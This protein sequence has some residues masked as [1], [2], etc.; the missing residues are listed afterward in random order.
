MGSSLTAV[1]RPPLTRERVPERVRRRPQLRR[2]MREEARAA[3]ARGTVLA[4][5]RAVPAR[6]QPALEHAVRKLAR[7]RSRAAPLAEL[8]ARRAAVVESSRVASSS[9]F[10]RVRERA[11]GPVVRARPAA[12]SD[13]KL[14]HPEVV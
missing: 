11:L 9:L 1:R 7:V 10:P 3:T 4:Q 14:V 5:L 12:S 2:V 8:R 6:V 13:F